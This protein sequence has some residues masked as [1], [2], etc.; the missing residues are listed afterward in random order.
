[1]IRNITGKNNKYS[2]VFFDLDGTIADSGEGCMNG[3]RYMFKSIGYEDYDEK[4]LKGFLGPAVKKHLIREYG[5]SEPQAEEAYSF[6]KDYY[7]N[8]G[9]YENRLYEGVTEAIDIIK[10]SGKYVYIATSKPDLQALRVLE[11]FGI[12]DMFT[13][14][15]AA[16][17]DLGIY[18]KNEVLEYAVKKLGGA[19]D[20]VMVGDRYFDIIGGK[21][22]GFDTVG[23]L[24]GYG[25]EK[26]LTQAGCDFTADST[27]DLAVF[28]GRGL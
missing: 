7:I 12:K 14:V 2:S 25:E 22:V 19:P 13:G 5:F 27:G 17:H 23:V 6:Y 20:S 10:R 11:H 9:M 1:M 16:R 26:E 18:D 28:L 15:F 3:V 4:K 21:H 8:K 24:Y